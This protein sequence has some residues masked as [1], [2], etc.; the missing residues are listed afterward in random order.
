MDKQQYKESKK[1]Y[2]EFSKAI[3]ESFDQLCATN[4]AL[5]TLLLDKC[6]LTEEEVSLIIERK[7]EIVKKLEE[8]RIPS[9]I[10]EQ[11]LRKMRNKDKESEIK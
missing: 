2:K 8:E 3:S 9:R 7:D 1:W 11:L 10:A 4:E 6:I 5:I